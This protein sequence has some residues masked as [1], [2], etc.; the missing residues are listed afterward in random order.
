MTRPCCRLLLSPPTAP[1]GVVVAPRS[2]TLKPSTPGLQNTPTPPTHTPGAPNA[3]VGLYRLV[4]PGVSSSKLLTLRPVGSSLIWSP[5]RLITSF[6]FCTSTTGAAPETMTV[7]DICPT[8][9]VPL[10]DAVNP[11][12]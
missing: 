8:L 1:P 5:E 11:L 10:T 3:D 2:P 9:R 12:V 7:S 4:M 6:A